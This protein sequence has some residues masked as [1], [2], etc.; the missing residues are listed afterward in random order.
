[1]TTESIAGI[2]TGVA[3][4]GLWI[5]TE[6]TLIGGSVITVRNGT[7]PILTDEHQ[8]RP[9]FGAMLQPRAGQPTE[10]QRREELLKELLRGQR[11]R[12]RQLK[13]RQLTKS[14]GNDQVQTSSGEGWAAH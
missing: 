11:Q 9:L 1:M 8:H 10:L 2:A 3:R 7:K 6:V 4:N 5:R 14:A 12:K 13:R